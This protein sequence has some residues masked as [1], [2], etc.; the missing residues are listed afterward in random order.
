MKKLVVA[1][2]NS[3]KLA[4]IQAYL[5]GLDCELVFIGNQ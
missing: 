3:G 1:T 5:V 4:E 2:G